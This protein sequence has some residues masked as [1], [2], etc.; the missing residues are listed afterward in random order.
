MKNAYEILY[1]LK[2]NM[3]EDAYKELSSN[4]QKWITGNGGEIILFKELGLRQLGPTFNVDPPQGYYVQCQFKGTAETVT[5]IT[6][7]IK[8]NETFVRHL[9][10]KMESIMTKTDLTKIMG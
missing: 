4:F 1:I 7:Q 9:I 2:P 6:D 3:A 10:V 5:A 8:V